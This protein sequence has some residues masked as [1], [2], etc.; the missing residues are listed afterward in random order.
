MIDIYSMVTERIIEQL[1]NG[2][3]PWER[4]WT[5]VREGAYN[6]ISKTPYSIMNQLL[7]KHPGEYATF[8]QWKDCG[9]H[10]K[11]G[12]KAEFVVFWKVYRKEEEKDNGDK[13]ERNIPVLRYYNVF[14]ISQVEGVEP[15]KEEELNHTDPIEEAEKLIHDY[16]TRECMRIIRE[17]T[18]KAYY[19]PVLDEIHAPLLEQFPEAAEAYSTYFHEIVHSTGHSK[20]LDRFQGG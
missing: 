1:E 17:K 3:I 2:Y 10:I 6:R 13:N 14:H 15:L 7:L 8:K 18:N 12:E 4:P 20:R 16:S 5:G 9:G 11:K 19:S